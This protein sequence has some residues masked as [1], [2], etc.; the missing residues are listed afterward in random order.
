MFI[1]IIPYV[2]YNKICHA[3]LT[4]PLTLN[5]TKM[6]NSKPTFLDKK[7]AFFSDA[8]FFFFLRVLMFSSNAI[9]RRTCQTTAKCVGSK[10]FSKE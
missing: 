4:I 7:N 2:S 8:S 5:K 3:L 10:T 1:Y 6:C 9:L